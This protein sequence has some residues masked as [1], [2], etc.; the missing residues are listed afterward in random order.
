[1]RRLRGDAVKVRSPGVLAFP[2][3]ARVRACDRFQQGRSLK[4]CAACGFAKVLHPKL[5]YCS[6]CGNDFTDPG[7]GH[8]YSACLE[9]EGRQPL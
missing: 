9:H 4:F 5:I 8:G 6:A 7:T 3:T 1:M 2:T